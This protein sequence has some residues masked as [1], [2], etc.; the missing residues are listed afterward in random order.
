VPD[1]LPP[2]ASSSP[3]RPDTQGRPP[4]PKRPLLRRP[5]TWLVVLAVLIGA[6]SYGR[7]WWTTLR[8]LQSTDD[9]YLRADQVAMAP[10]VSGYVS[11]VLVADNQAV[12]AGQVLVRID[13]STYRAALAQQASTRDARQGDVVVA[14]AQYQQELAGVDQ[15]AARLGGDEANLR[16][17]NRQVDRYRGLAATG[18]EPPEKLAQMLNQ[19]DQAEAT[20]HTDAAALEAARRQARTAEA[21][22]GQARDQVAVAQAAA[23][24]AQLDVDHTEIR[25]S[26]SGRVGDKTVQAGQF[27]QPGTRMLSLVPVQDIYVVANFRETQLDGMHAGQ[28]ASVRVDAL[29]GRRLDATIQSFAPGTGAQFS[30][31]P[32]E[33]AT[34]NFTK[35][36][37]R[38]PVRLRLSADKDTLVRLMPGLSVVVEVDTSQPSAPAD[39][40]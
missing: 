13:P 14:E 20:L 4:P 36:V 28:H 15:A 25:A 11:E 32:P 33:N 3:S 16:F 17:A 21:K 7:Y 29:D 23:A 9:A 40:S 10:R 38:V 6:G 12:T 19:Q 2:Q 37:Q 39:G 8:F 18:A 30:L 27:V 1:T 35:I 31:L 24:S 5:V 22:V 26:I 34:G